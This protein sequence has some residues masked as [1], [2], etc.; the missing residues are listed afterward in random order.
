MRIC[1]AVTVL[2]A[3]AVPSFAGD[4]AKKGQMDDDAR[5]ATAKALEWLA[6]K[7]AANGSWGDNNYQNNTAITGFALMA[8][9]SQGNVPNQGKYGREVAKGVRFLMASQRDDG[10][11]IGAS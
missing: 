2:L 10:Y 9:M 8:F 3:V 4:K 6:S 11:L 1:L 7:Q 5:K